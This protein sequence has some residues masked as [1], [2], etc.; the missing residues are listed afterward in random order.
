M[1]GYSSDWASFTL[2]EA[3]KLHFDNASGNAGP[4][5]AINVLDPALQ[6]KAEETTVQLQFVNGRAT[7]Q[8]DTII[9]DTLALADKVE[10]EDYSVDYNYTT[11][12][13]IIQSVGETPITGQV[14]TS[15]TEVDP[16]MV[17]ADDIIGGVTAG[18]VYS[19]LGVVGLVY[20]ET[21]LIPNLLAAPAGRKSPRYITR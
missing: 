12:E 14:S 4:V 11:G 9:L 18:G 16:S 2:C 19:G 10:G 15:Y 7:I 6:Q 13:V 3:F 1:M 5:I 17:D 20:P 8:S 21:G